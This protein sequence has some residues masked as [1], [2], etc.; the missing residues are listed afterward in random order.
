MS[1]WRVL[2]ALMLGFVMGP[3]SAWAQP[4]EVPIIGVLATE[5]GPDDPLLVVFRQGL[6]DL[7]YVEGKNLRL[8][9]RTAL[10][11]LDRLGGLARE[12]VRMK[13]D[14]VLTA[15]PLAAQ[16]LKKASSTVPIVVALFDP[17]VSG[18]VTNLARPGGNITGLSSMAV[19]LY[20]KRLQLLK[21]LVPGLQR[22]VV[23]WNTSALPAPLQSKF[24]EEIEAAAQTL[25]VD[26]KFIAAEKPEGFD[27]AFSAIKQDQPQALYL[28]ENAV[29][30]VHRKVLASMAA[31]AG[32]P[33]LYGS[34]V[35][36]EAGGLVSYGVDYADQIRRSARYVDRI[37]K[38]ARPGDLPIEQP[39]K[40]ELVVNWRTA[41]ALGLSI[42]DAVLLK[43]DEVIR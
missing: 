9:F 35:F 19:D 30:Y 42:P 3:S 13:A 20:S 6:R 2:L 21:E 25:S 22:V 36:V 8:E 41:K 1:A 33:I 14:V 40:F 24:V 39:T 43:A 7:G 28:H 32:L 18:L 15:N 26:L 10:G 4:S 38:G 11:Q 27:S 31:D 37:L 23:L 29:F 12:L 34:K 17:V 16:A 5:A